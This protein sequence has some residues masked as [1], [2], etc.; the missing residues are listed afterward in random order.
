MSI[1]VFIRDP[2][3]KEGVEIL[4]EASFDV[5]TQKIKECDVLIVRSKFL[6]L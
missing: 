6:Q 3:A 4:R 1:K 2:I 5:D